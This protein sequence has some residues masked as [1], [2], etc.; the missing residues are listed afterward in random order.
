M[1]KIKWGYAENAGINLDGV[2]LTGRSAQQGARAVSLLAT[3]V[4][5]EK[6]TAEHP[7]K[8]MA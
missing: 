3:D 1:R 2:F 5:D 6:K 7:G 8:A 4:I